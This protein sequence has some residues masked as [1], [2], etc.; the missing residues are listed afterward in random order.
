MLTIFKIL[1]RIL[2]LQILGVLY[3]INF[4]LIS[5]ITNSPQL[6]LN[7]SIKIH[8]CLKIITLYLPIKNFGILVEQVFFYETF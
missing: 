5:Y 3:F 7:A 8:L 2:K 6:P 4:Q 1:L